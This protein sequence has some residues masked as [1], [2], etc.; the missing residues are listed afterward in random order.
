MPVS[1]PA[2]LLQPAVV[3]AGAE[4]VV[5]AVVAAVAEQTAESVAKRT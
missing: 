5:D 2:L 3:T 4:S 1:H